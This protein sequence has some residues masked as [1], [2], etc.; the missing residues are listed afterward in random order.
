MDTHFRTAPHEHN[1]PVQLG[2][3]SVWNVSFLGYPARAILP[4]TQALAKLAPHIQQVGQTGLDSGV[5]AHGLSAQ[6]CQQMGRPQGAWAH[7]ALARPAL[8][9][10]LKSRPAFCWSSAGLLES[11][12]RDWPSWPHPTGVQGWTTGFRVHLRPGVLLQAPPLCWQAACL[13]GSSDPQEAL[14]PNAL[15]R[16]C[17]ACTRWGHSHGAPDP[18]TRWSSSCGH[19]SGAGPPPQAH[20]MS[21]PCVQVSM[22]SNGK[23]VSID[24]TRLPFEAGEVDFGEP[25]TN[26]QHSFYQLIHQGRVI[27]AEFIGIVKSQQS[28]YLKVDMRCTSDGALVIK[29]MPGGNALTKSL[30]DTLAL[31]NLL[32]S[33]T[34]I[35]PAQPVPQTGRLYSQACL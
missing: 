19:T 22:E 30:T 3:M 7:W 34:S 11:S 31:K 13:P 6:C 12:T 33:V 23:G 20:I 9:L 27:P 15:Q 8:A 17:T 29:G 18:A 4:Y 24:G 1:I 32:S 14:R 5:A 16:I 28:V 35:Q 25:G 2:L 26:G 21:P 10:Q